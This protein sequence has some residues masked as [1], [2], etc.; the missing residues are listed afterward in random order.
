MAVDALHLDELRWIPAGR[1]WQKTR[2][3]TSAAHR[4]AMVRLVIEGHANFRLERCEIEREGP[5]YTLD[6]VRQLQQAD[7][8]ASWLLIVGADQY[9]GLHTWRD[10]TELLTRV[11]LAVA[12]RPGPLPAPDPQVQRHPHR[13][14]PLPMRDIAS[15]DIRRRVAAGLSIDDLVP[16]PV[17]RYIAQH[18]LYTKG[19]A[20]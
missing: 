9:A 10:W 20:H 14:V 13:V 4:E 17:A 15:T 16:P 12:A 2:S 3:V 7:A 8:G 18:S 1:P 5:S 11:E 19:S 6:T